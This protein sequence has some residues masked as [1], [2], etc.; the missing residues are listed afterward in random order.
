MLHK[1]NCF[2]AEIEGIF[3]RKILE[4]ANN[5]S[6][7]CTSLAIGSDRQLGKVLLETY[8]YTLSELEI[9]P[10]NIFLLNEAVLLTLPISDCCL[11]LKRFQDRGVEILVC[12]TSANYYDIVKKMQVGKLI[13]MKTI[14][15]KQLG[16]TKLIN[17]S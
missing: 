7:V 3:D 17:I 8:I 14:I 13:G 5:I 11:Y 9:L 1:E 15:E 6:F 16:A 12:D 10:K 4:E 2:I